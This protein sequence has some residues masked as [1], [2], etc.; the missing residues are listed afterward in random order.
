LKGFVSRLIASSSSSALFPKKPTVHFYP[1]NHECP[2][3]SSRLHVQKT[4]TKTAVTMDIGAFRAK[5]TV[6]FCPQD[7]TTFIAEQ[8]R[9]L[10]PEGGTFGFD[11]IVET[12]LA[13]FVHCRNNQ[14]AMKELAAKNVFVSEREISFLGR[15]F[16]IYL[17]LAHRESQQRLR[18]LM[19]RRGGYILHVDGTCEGDSPNLFCGLDGISELVL[20]TIKIPS[21]KKE[22][23]SPFFQR[24]KEQYGEP[25][26]LV[27]DMGK[28]IVTAVEEVFPGV[29]DFICHFHFLRDVGK[30][31]LLA[32]YTDLQ[33]RLRKLKVRSLLRHRSKYLEQKINPASQTIEEIT[34]S[35][36][37]G[38]WQTTSLEH[39]PLITTY[40]L[41]HW[42]FEYPRQSSGYG[43]PFDRPHLDFYRRLQKVHRLLWEIMDVHLRGAVK[44]NKPFFQVY[45]TFK[46]AVED[47]RLNDLAASLERKAEVFDKLRTAMRIALPEGKNGINDNG[48][49]T[50]MKSIEGKVTTFKKWLVSDAR[51]KATYAGMIA[52]LDKY[53]DKLFADPLP[54]VTPE[55]ILYIQPQR[56]NNILERFFRGEKRRGRKKNGMASLS[57]VLKA[58]LADTPLVQN[59][60]NSEYM[61][62]ILN[63]CSSLAERFS[64]IDAHLV[65]KKLENAKNSKERILPAVKKLIRDSDLVTK[66]A[67]LFS[68][69]AK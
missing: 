43:F 55:G 47:K 41:I 35:L 4:H 65:Q 50:D 11:V 34:S 6:L 8:L 67:K 53:W 39:I 1:E 7:Q 14:E 15:K 49:D 10:V 45:R 63:G 59:L 54:V 52:Q 68:S 58:A 37:S 60:K 61:E 26:A 20:D 64:Q 3:C 32:E 62:I 17:A 25:K 48:D 29:A 19:A 46:K 22:L 12:G 5:E 21:E 36:E 56:T 69:C 38:A 33:K 24:I 40:A 31:L 51:R 44:D 2:T 13:L 16:I 27:H 66:I 9:R 18:D 42:V 57:K 23:L 28:G 30:D